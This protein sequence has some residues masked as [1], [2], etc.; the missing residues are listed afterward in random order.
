MLDNI[1]PTLAGAE[2]ETDNE[3]ED[4]VN[5]ADKDEVLQGA[6]APCSKETLMT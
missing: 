2:E 3:E 6:A 4:E 1:E 5:E